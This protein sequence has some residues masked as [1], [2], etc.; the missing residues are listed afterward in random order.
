MIEYNTR[1]YH[2]HKL[3]RNINI[4]EDYEVV[5]NKRTLTRS[6]CPYYQSD[7]KVKCNG[8]ND[9]GFSCGYAVYNINSN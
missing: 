2:C 8:I 3:K 7:E 1:L 9:H 6:V 4:L 5:N